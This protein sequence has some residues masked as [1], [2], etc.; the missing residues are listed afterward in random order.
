M[1]QVIHARARFR[2]EL[3]SRPQTFQLDQCTEMIVDDTSC[4]AS[5]ESVSSSKGA[6][7]RCNA[8]HGRP[9]S[10]RSRSS[11]APRSLNTSHS[12][13]RPSYR[14]SLECETNEVREISRPLFEEAY[15][16]DAKRERAH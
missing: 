6:R 12:S 2:N 16:D 13:L 4:E 14:K 9:R 10:Y 5:P 15:S 8:V 1:I 3:W 7:A 11:S